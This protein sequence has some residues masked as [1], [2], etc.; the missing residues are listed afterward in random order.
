MESDYD[1]ILKESQ[2]QANVVVRWDVG[3]NKKRLAFFTLPKLELGE[4]R[5]VIGDELS[6][7]YSG[8]LH[9]PWEGPGNVIKVPDSK[10]YH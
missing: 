8:E 4:V 10:S 2:T 1:K 3:L 5:L 6:L 9:A 7:K